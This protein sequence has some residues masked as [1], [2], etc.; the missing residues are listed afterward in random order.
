MR[1]GVGLSLHGRIHWR[2]WLTSSG[3]DILE[4]LVYWRGW[5]MS[6]GTE[7][8]EELVYGRIGSLL[9]GHRHW[10][11]KLISSGAQIFEGL[12]HFFRDIN[13]RKFGSFL[14]GQVGWLVVHQLLCLLV[15]LFDFFV[16]QRPS[17][18]QKYPR[19]EFD[20]TYIRTASPS[21]SLQIKL[22]IPQFSGKVSTCH[23]TEPISPS[24]WQGSRLS[25]SG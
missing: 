18:V 14:Q 5:F 8:L 12:V 4:G 2:S 1:W 20:F 21:Q 6:S 15:Y 3:T 17:K 7:I 24:V 10:R 16:D 23:S 13:S 11:R 22:A 19:D 9:Q 25:T